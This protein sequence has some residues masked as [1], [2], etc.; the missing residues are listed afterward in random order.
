MLP[1]HHITKPVLI[2]EILEDGQ[3]DVVW[4]TDGL[5]PGDAWSD[6][7]AG[8]EGP[9]L[10]LGGQEVRQLQH[11]NGQ[12]R[13]RSIDPPTSAWWRRLLPAPP[14]TD[15]ERSIEHSSDPI[16][17]SRGPTRR[18]GEPAGMAMIL[19][20]LIATAFLIVAGLMTAVAQEA[21]RDT[22]GGAQMKAALQLFA[23]GSYC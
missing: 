19:R 6:L 20:R 7:P 11:Q 9:G 12:V 22:D 21:A 5:V 3:F 14:V 2:G 10:R 17:H 15:D 1:N 23:T 16:N 13:Q 4:K 18:G 8:F